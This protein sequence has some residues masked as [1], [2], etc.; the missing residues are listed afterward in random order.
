ML[1]V[2]SL[3][4]AIGG[5]FCIIVFAGMIVEKVKGGKMSISFS[6][7]WMVCVYVFVLLFAIYDEIDYVRNTVPD[8]KYVLNISVQFDENEEAYYLP[9]ELVISTEKDYESGTYYTG[10]AEMTST[11]ITK[12]REF[13]LYKIDFEGKEIIIDQDV[14]PEED[15]EIDIG[16]LYEDLITVNIG[17]ISPQTLGIKP[18]DNWTNEGLVGKAETIIV[19]LSSGFLLFQYFVLD[20]GR[21]KTIEEKKRIRN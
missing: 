16:D 3:A 9:A 6:T 17:V 18:I 7:D 14:Y 2:I 8:G 13:Y 4:Y 15:I 20:S 19:I 1:G 11:R 21:K 12:N 10:A 5:I